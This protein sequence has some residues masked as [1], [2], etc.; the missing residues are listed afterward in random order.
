MILRLMQE[1]KII[2]NCRGFLHCS[3][4]EICHPAMDYLPYGVYT[5]IF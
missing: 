5:M 2:R 1:K 4:L 3:D